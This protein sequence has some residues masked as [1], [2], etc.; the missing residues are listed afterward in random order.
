VA[1]F[2]GVEKFARPPA[3]LYPLLADC[4]FLAGCLPDAEVTEATPD[5]A[6]W[7]MRP[8]LSF[9]SGALETVL[10][11]GTRTP[12]EAVTFTVLGKGIGAT[13]TVQTALTLKPVEGG[14]EVH[15]TGEL[16]ALTGLLK[17]VPKGLIQSTAQKVIAD[18]WASVRVRIEN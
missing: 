6:A 13:S 4:G 8:K 18:V 3:D 14:T 16:T 9:L 7:K 15:W 17:M 11:I 2:E 12:G 1:Q 10:T 5:R